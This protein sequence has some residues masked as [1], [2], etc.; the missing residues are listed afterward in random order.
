MCIELFVCI[1]VYS[2]LAVIYCDSM[3]KALSSAHAHTHT[4][5]EK[6][7][8]CIIV[9]ILS[10]NINRAYIWMDICIVE[11]YPTHK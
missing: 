6:I 11:T 2:L 9:L 7:T 4:Q 3:K 10:I 1:S 5:Y 8:T